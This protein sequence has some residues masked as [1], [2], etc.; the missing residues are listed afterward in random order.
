[1]YTVVVNVIWQMMSRVAWNL[2]MVY[3]HVLDQI[4]GESRLFLLQCVC[5]FIV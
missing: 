1:M 3:V 2:T 5:V 4:V